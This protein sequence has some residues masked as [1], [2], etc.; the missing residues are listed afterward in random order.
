MLVSLIY[1]NICI[2][3]NNSNA[4]AVP[5]HK[6]KNYGGMIFFSFR[7]QSTDAIFAPSNAMSLTTVSTIALHITVTN[8]LPYGPMF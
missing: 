6:R 5:N 3:C 2:S 8:K 1:T 4:D 7:R